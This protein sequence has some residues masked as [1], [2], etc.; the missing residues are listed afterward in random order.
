MDSRATKINKV[1]LN[2]LLVAGF[3]SVALIAPN[4]VLLFDPKRR[5]RLW[6]V[7]KAF[8]NLVYSGCIKVIKGRAY[9]T[10]K[11]S[12]LL[13]GKLIANIG[14][15]K[16]WDRKWR[17]VSFDIPEKVRRSRLKLRITLKEI[18]FIKLQNS[19]WVYP[20]DCKWFIHLLKN[21]FKIGKDVIYMTVDEI[22]HS[23]VLKKH[24]KL[25]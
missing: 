19:L 22:E 1:I 8:N 5:P 20:Y 9:I 13:G 4:A 10:K 17:V 6:D 2:S 16:K 3:V 14:K 12:L 24:F 21:D 25:R 23:Q 18:G 7:R 11:G 15:I